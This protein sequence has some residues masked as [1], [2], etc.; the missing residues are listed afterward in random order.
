VV[1][2]DAIPG[3]HARIP[4]TRARTLPAPMLTVHK[5]LLVPMTST[6]VNVVRTVVVLDNFVPRRP[7][8]ACTLPAQVLTVHKFL[9]ATAINVNVVRTVV[10]LDKL[11]PHRPTPAHILLVQMKLMAHNHFKESK[12]AMET[13]LAASAV[14]NAAPQIVATNNCALLPLTRV[15]IKIAQ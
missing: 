1:R 9:L 15:L 3:K 12:I 4:A 13:L 14:V 2:R 5:F 6:P 8:R 10:I 11:V 7:A